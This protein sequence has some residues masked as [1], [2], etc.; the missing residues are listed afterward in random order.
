MVLVEVQ[1]VGDQRI[2]YTDQRGAVEGTKPVIIT[3]SGFDGSMM[4]SGSSDSQTIS[5]TMDDTSGDLRAI[6]NAN[7]IHKRP[8]RV[9]MLPKGSPTSDKILVFR[10]EVVTPLEWDEAKRTMSFNIL[11]K[12]EEKQVGFS[13]EEGDFPNIPEE[14]LGKAWPLVF[15][16]VCHLPAVK[17]RAPRR[18]Y[19]E[20]GEGIHDFT[21]EPRIC[22]AVRIECPSQSTGNQSLMTQGANNTWSTS[23]DKTVGPD[24]EC[25][26]R[27]FGEICMLRDLLVQQQ[28]YE[29]STMN[30]YNGVSFPQGSNVTIF[31]DNATFTGFFTDNVFTIN[32][33]KHPEYDTFNHVA[34]RA[35]P[36][37]GYGSVPAVAQFGGT[38]NDR[39]S[40]GGYW[41][42]AHGNSPGSGLQS[43]TW[44]PA[45]NSTTFAANQTQGQAFASCDEALSSAPG[46]IGGP[47]DSWAYY[48]AME[49]SD[50]FWAAPGSEVYM[51]SES[52]ILY[53]ASLIPGVVNGVAA[54]RTAPNGIRYLTQ[55]PTDYYTVY[56]TDYQGYQVVEIGLNKAL[57]L[58][59]D[60]WDD[61]LYVSFTSTVGPNPCDIIEWLL[62]KYTGVTADATSFAAVHAK[63]VDYPAGF[64]ILDRPDVYNLINDIAY[65]SR[66][67]VAIRNDVMFITYLPSEPTSLRTFTE[68]DILHDTFTEGLSQ[69]EEVYTTHNITWQP[70]GA[71]TRDDRD[72]E[73]KLILKYNVD[74]YGTVDQDWDY[75][76]HNV[77]DQ[78]LHAATFW[79]IRKSNS[80]KKVTFTAPFK[81]MDLDV[82][83]CITLD[84]AQFGSAVKVVIEKSSVDPDSNTVSFECWTPI[85]SGETEEYY[86][87]WPAEKE[88]RDVWPLPLDT[89]GGGGYNFVVE[90]PEG[91][92]LLGGAHRD[93]QLIISSGE[94]HPSDGCT[95]NSVPVCELS[96]YLNFD[97]E[98]PDIQA[99]AIAQSAARQAMENGMT[100]GGNAGGGGDSKRRSI[101]GCGKGAGCNYKVNVTWH[102]SASQGLAQALGGNRGGYNGK[103]G[104]PCRCRGGCPSCF[105]PV[106]VVCHTFGS[107]RIAGSA[108]SYWKSAYGA[109]ENAWWNC[110]ETRVMQVGVTEGTHDPRYTNNGEDC[111][112]CSFHD[113]QVGSGDPEEKTGK[114][115][116]TPTNET[117][118]ATGQTG[119]EPA[120]GDPT[121]GETTAGSVQD[122]PH[123]N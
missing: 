10:G 107:C 42:V 113:A 84:V 123:Y 43:A 39:N 116:E 101:D 85:R 90:P 103:C 32:N 11:S 17:V 55:V 67:S 60:S 102:T 65:Q 121:E 98:S 104:G 71:D 51:E 14:A 118:E 50:F 49:A 69:T 117:S 15:G 122:N 109:R 106:W 6:Y 30:I 29:H 93:D 82:G 21:L 3:M 22:Q 95:I 4:L 45:N 9:Y 61:Q 100:G 86:W 18:G 120:A 68:S 78:V 76:C 40:A 38:N 19:L 34:C 35:V 57:T 91:H 31:I 108:A 105:G 99:K 89:N 88:C 80:W 5:L 8:A 62:D 12:L 119:S 77:Y 24:L 36:A 33:R 7:D 63:L 66:C 44:V 47:K 23:I 48:D 97:E 2:I 54:Y 64:Y 56:L 72:I 114:D 74:K 112:G 79:L 52:E 1:W 20:N 16:E 81:H 27:R 92:L 110:N 37:F 75:Y 41:S 96:D 46:M 26:N 83:D 13:M 53:I 28:A 115:G 87:A 25:V 70:A 58:Y 94:L 59:D 73:R 111:E